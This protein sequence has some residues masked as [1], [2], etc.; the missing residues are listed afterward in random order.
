MCLCAKSTPSPSR[1]YLPIGIDV[2]QVT[3]VVNF[4]LPTN[5]DNFTDFDTY[6]HRIGRAGRF[7]KKG[8]AFNMVERNKLPLLYAIEA[9]FSEYTVAFV[10][11]RAEH[12][13]LDPPE[14]GLNPCLEKS[15]LAFHFHEIELQG[16]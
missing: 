10:P 5:L 11:V 4:S 16:S 2:E 13:V 1:S 14:W 9:H 7:G 3:I 12:Q 6:L 15:Q 8:L